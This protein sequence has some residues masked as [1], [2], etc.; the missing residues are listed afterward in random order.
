MCASHKRYLTPFS[1][2]WE[3]RSSIVTSDN[4]YESPKTADG[5]GEEFK[6]APEHTWEGHTF[7]IRARFLP[8]SLFMIGEHAVT[9]DHTE[10]FTS[11][12]LRLN[13]R[14]DF[15][16]QHQDRTVAARYETFGVVLGGERYRLIVDGQ[17]VAE[18]K[19]RIPLWWLNFMIGILIG[20]TIVLIPMLFL[21]LL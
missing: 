7:T 8:K 17:L 18:S 16:F 1:R 21:L 5:V 11:S 2:T 10:T 12:N 4:P 3:F 6:L 9:L 13:E 14:I 20:I 19:V 15:T